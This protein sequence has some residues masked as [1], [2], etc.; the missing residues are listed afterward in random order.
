MIYKFRKSDLKNRNL[1]ESSDY[2]SNGHWMVRKA[3]LFYDYKIDTEELEDDSAERVIPKDTSLK[4]TRTNLIESC[5]DICKKEFDTV[6]FHGKD[7][8][9]RDVF[10]GFNRRYVEI[11]NLE[12]LYGKDAGSAFTV[13]P[14]THNVIIMP[15]RVTFDGRFKEGNQ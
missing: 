7:S 9:E 10:V 1:V 11:F 13:D 2:L 3:L 5:G 8:K 15:K 12:E 4:I 14:E 6:I